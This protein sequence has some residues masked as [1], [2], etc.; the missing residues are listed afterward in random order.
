MI[1]SKKDGRIGQRKLNKQGLWMEVM[2]YIDNKHVLIAFDD[3]TLVVKRWKSF[4]DGATLH[5]NYYASSGMS[6]REMRLG[7]ERVNNQGYKMKIVEYIDS[8]NI[9][10]QFDDD[11]ANIVKSSYEQFEC[12]GIGN[13]FASTTYGIGVM[14]NEYPSKEK[15]H[16][17]KEYLA[18]RAMIARCYSEARREEHPSYIGCQV[19]DEFLYYPN[20]YKW[21][22]Q[23][24]NYGIWKASQWFALDKD[25][26]VK[27]NNI[28]A[29]DRCC[30]VPPAINSLFRPRLV[31]KNNLPPGVR[32][33]INKQKYEA[34][35][36]NPILKK[37]IGLGFFES[38][39]QAFLVYKDHKEKLL[40]EIAD[41]EYS[42]GTIST[43]CRD[44]L[45]NYIIE[46]TD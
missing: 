1:H 11:E 36:W 2:D 27:N 30:L 24:E 17:T 40:K 6:L 16:Y 3:G 26:L 19:S 25:I 18:W 23:Q 34:R 29:P 9:M 45:A 32:I 13:P 37:S 38:P 7:E 10:V 20:F 44:A 14:G 39:H 43:R 5:P 4:E 46:E 22:T 8:H 15:G 12:G 35:L 31:R 41:K 28:Y 33:S 42:K 21:I